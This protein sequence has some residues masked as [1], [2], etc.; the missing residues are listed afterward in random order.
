MTPRFSDGRCISSNSLLS[1]KTSNP[2]YLISAN[3]HSFSS[4][5]SST[6][7]AL[8]QVT[9][10]VANTVVA[11]EASVM[12]ACEVVDYL[13]AKGVKRA[14]LLAALH[15]KAA[16]KEDAHKIHC[17][18]IGEN[19]NPLLPLNE[20]EGAWAKMDG[21]TSLKDNFIAALLPFL[22]VKQIPVLCLFVPGY[23]V[24][25]RGDDGTLQVRP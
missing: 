2:W 21:S 23:R 25:L 10:V 22:E 24:T 9:L 3:L 4:S 6:T 14:T 18:T 13:S 17:H 8:D 1:I 12:L 15:F 11:A 5:A 16:K 20:G 7:N 19:Q